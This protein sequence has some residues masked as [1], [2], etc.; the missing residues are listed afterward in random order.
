MLNILALQEL[1]EETVLDAPLSS[2]SVV[3][4]H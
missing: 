1:D 3:V 4:C 2:V